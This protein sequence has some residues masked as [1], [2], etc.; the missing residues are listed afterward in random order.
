MVPTAKIIIP[1]QLTSHC[2]YR[3][4]YSAQYVYKTYCRPKCV[5]RTY[6]INWCVH[7]T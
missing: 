3:I 1:H 6:L 2:A 7:R 4:H 5:Y